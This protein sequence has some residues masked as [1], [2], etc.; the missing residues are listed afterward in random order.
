MSR[1][2]A[3]LALS[4]ALAAGIAPKSPPTLRD[5]VAVPLQDVGKTNKPDTTHRQARILLDYQETRQRSWETKSLGQIFHFGRDTEVRSLRG[6][7]VLEVPD[8]DLLHSFEVPGTP[9]SAPA[10]SPRITGWNYMGPSKMFPQGNEPAKLEVGDRAKLVQC[11]GSAEYRRDQEFNDKGLAEYSKSQWR[12]YKTTRN[13]LGSLPL[14]QLGSNTNWSMMFNSQDGLDFFRYSVLPIPVTEKEVSD[15]KSSSREFSED[16]HLVIP[17][18]KAREDKGW[19]FNRRMD[20]RGLQVSG[21]LEKNLSD[22]SIV[23]GAIRVTVD[24]DPAEYECLIKPPD[25]YRKWLPEGGD[26]EEQVVSTLQFTGEIRC[27][28]GKP[29]P[30]RKFWIETRLDS[31]TQPGV[32]VNFPAHGKKTA[33]LVIQRQGTSPYLELKSSEGKGEDDAW[34]KATGNLKAGQEFTVAVGCRDYGAF[35]DLAFNCDVPVRIEGFDDHRGSL[36]LPF[37][38]N[39]N[40]I[41]DNWE[42]WASIMA[43]AHA[44]D[45][46]LPSGNG[47]DGDGLSVY[48]EYRGFKC[49]GV[50]TRTAPFYKDLFIH[51]PG[52]L[53]CGLFRA[54]GITVHFVR[55]GEFSEEEGAENKYVINC[56]R[57]YATLGQQHL[58]FVRNHTFAN[59]SMGKA[60][61]PNIGPPKETSFVSVDV[62][63]CR[64]RGPDRLASTLAH[65]LGHGCNLWHHGDANYN[66]RDLMF[67]G[68]DNAWHDAPG[69]AGDS[70]RVVAAGGAQCSGV[71]NCIMRYMRANFYAKAGGPWAWR[72]TP[73]GDLIQGELYP[74]GP[75]ARTLFCTDPKGTGINDAGYPGG[76][77]AGNAIRGNCLHQFQV[78]DLKPPKVP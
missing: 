2:L 52:N 72:E 6:M 13:T 32:C 25:N 57:A 42:Y 54:S 17:P 8:E 76:S 35:G 5:D 24:L 38:E 33:D 55:A 66:A 3:A 68:T 50:H 20:P 26:N 56:N 49:A 21:T 10:Q 65:E 62:A 75:F 39:H 45:D 27:I 41:A 28:K 77:V 9:I 63:K 46:K 15:G 14:T 51:D 34:T 18:L 37:D 64:A 4:L 36:N 58:L 70:G 48:E 61:G 74:A 23:H 73:E 44:D 22:G 11:T 7:I 43:N 53:G 12:W 16:V 30:D 67:Y 29:L 40:R 59:G 1:V 69:G 31:S 71:E 47:V 60:E 19:V 78:N